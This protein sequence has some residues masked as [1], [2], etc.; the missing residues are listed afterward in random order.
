MKGN[1]HISR[2]FNYET[3]LFNENEKRGS[4]VCFHS[5][6]QNISTGTR[7]HLR[8]FVVVAAVVLVW[9]ECRDR[10]I[11]HSHKWVSLWFNPDTTRFWCDM[12]TDEHLFTTFFFRWTTKMFI[13][14]EV[15]FPL[16]VGEYSEYCKNDGWIGGP[17]RKNEHF[18]WDVQTTFWKK[19][20]TD[21]KYQKHLS[22]PRCGRKTLQYSVIR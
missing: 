8:H 14:I 10:N 22:Q 15:V 7:N 12:T 11:F 6:E 9:V 5:E 19:Y 20:P 16:A 1:K 4:K 17:T 18:L 2:N 21:T 3:F 13:G